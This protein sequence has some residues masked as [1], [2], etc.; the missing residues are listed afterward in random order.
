MAFQVARRRREI[1]VRMAVGASPAEAAGL[2]LRQA[3]GLMAAG[4]AL[5][6]L[7]ALALGRLLAGMLF[8]VAPHD[9]VSLAAVPAILGAA[10]LAAAW[11]PARSASRVDPAAVLRAE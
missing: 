4:L 1:A 5:G 6:L 7:A 10:G 2:V 11:L 8:G 3:A 9:P